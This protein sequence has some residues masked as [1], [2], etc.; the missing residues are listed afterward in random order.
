MP[1]SKDYRFHYPRTLHETYRLP[2]DFGCTQ[3]DSPSLCGA[4]MELAIRLILKELYYLYTKSIPVKNWCGISVEQYTRANP[5]STFNPV[6][7]E[8]LCYLNQPVKRLIRDVS[9]WKTFCQQSKLAEPERR[10]AYW[11]PK[12]QHHK[13]TLLASIKKLQ[14]GL[15]QTKL[16][17]PEHIVLGKLYNLL[18]KSE[19]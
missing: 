18:Q 6:T 10:L 12:S 17:S 9:L 11:G 3:G 14:R 16:G 2:V 13:Q 19:M 5:L 1:L 8:I 4:R 15:T 7:Q